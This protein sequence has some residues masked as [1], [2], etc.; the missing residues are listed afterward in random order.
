M[1]FYNRPKILGQTKWSA[2]IRPETK[3][4]GEEWSVLI[5]D[6][7]VQSLYHHCNGTKGL[8]SQTVLFLGGPMEYT[9]C[10]LCGAW[11]NNN[12]LTL[13]KIYNVRL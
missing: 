11:P 1:P 8:V 5:Q 9:T 13:V 12:I 6:E 10:D 3:R 7:M 4:I 2:D